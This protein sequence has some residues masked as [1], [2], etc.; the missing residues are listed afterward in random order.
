[1]PSLTSVTMEGEIFRTSCAPHQLK[2]YQIWPHFVPKLS[3]FV[4]HVG[5]NVG[6]QLSLGPLPL[7]LAGGESTNDSFSFVH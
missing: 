1:M 7:C 2:Y 3:F 4:S 5:H 6:T